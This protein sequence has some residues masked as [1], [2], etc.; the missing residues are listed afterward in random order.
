MTVI[1][2]TR[3][4]LQGTFYLDDVRLIA[5]EP[6]SS[7]TAVL[8]AHQGNTPEVFSLDQNY[9]NPFNRG[10]VI[11]FDLP[12][13]QIV[14]LAVYNLAGQ[15]VATLI[16]G[17]RP[18]GAYTMRWDGRNEE[19]QTLASGLYFYRLSGD[20]FAETRQMVLVK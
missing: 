13:R 6:P 8:E 17:F 15:Q 12:R 3:G 10:T 1:S 4:N 5:E 9:P 11:R 19:G 2:T 7:D 18:A 20:R 16:H 14:D